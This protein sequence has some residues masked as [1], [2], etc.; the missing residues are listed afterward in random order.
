MVKKN[1]LQIVCW[2]ICSKIRCFM[3]CHSPPYNTHC[4]PHTSHGPSQYH[5]QSIAQSH[6]PK[7]A[8]MIGCPTPGNMCSPG[9]ELVLH[10]SGGQLCGGYSHMDWTIYSGKNLIEYTLYILSVIYRLWR[11]YGDQWI[12]CTRCRVLPQLCFGDRW[13]LTLLDVDYRSYKYGKVSDVLK[14]HMYTLEFFC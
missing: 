2:Y 13:E 10:Y 6:E 4:T 5:P 14:V 7:C 1:C 9:S 12:F 11:L 8:E 3:S